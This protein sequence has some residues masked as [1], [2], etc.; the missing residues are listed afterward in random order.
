MPS[1]WAGLTVER[2]AADAAST[3]A[4]F[5]RLIGL[6]RARTEFTGDGIEW[7]SAPR[8]VLIFRRAGGAV[9]TLNAGRSP[10]ALPPGELLVSSA[11]LVD[12]ALPPDAAA[13][14]V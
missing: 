6:R 3:L 4:L 5:R 7:L 12:G 9:C 11:P 8:D 13:W 1:D 2:Q 10:M 14:L